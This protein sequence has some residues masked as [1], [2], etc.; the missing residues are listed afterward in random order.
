MKYAAIFL[1][2]ALLLTGCSQ[3]PG[4]STAPSQNTSV[5][6]EPSQST[7]TQ[8]ILP[9][10]DALFSD[11]DFDTSV[12]GGT[13]IIL[14][15]STIRCTGSGVTVSGN[16]ATITEEGT[17][18]L[19]GQLQNGSIRIDTDKQSKVQL[20]LR[21]AAIHCST[22]APICVLQADKVFLT[23]EGSNE[24]SNG[25]SFESSEE[26]VDAVLFSQDDLTINGS[27]SM[28]IRSPGGHGIVAKDELTITGGDFSITAAKHGI[29]A[30]DSL[31]I[32]SG[33]FLIQSGKDAL[34]SDS[35]EE[36]M[37]F[38]YIR[39][40]EFE[41]DATGDGI[42]A[43]NT[44]QIDGGV[45]H[46]TTGGGSENGE[47]HT[48]DLFGPG[49]MG[50]G[51]PGMGRP[52]DMPSSSTTTSTDSSTS[53]K[54]LKAGSN[55][56]LLGGS[57]TINSSD[58][59]LHGN[60][61]V[62]IANGTLTIATGD[63]AIHADAT[64]TISG[65]IVHITESYEGMEAQSIR[66]LGGETTLKASDDGLNAAGGNDQSG[67][68]GRP[69]DHFAAASDSAIEITG[70]SLFVDADG[71]GIDSNGS[72]T[73]TGGYTVVEGPTNGGNGPLDYGGSATI[74]GGTL[75]VTGSVQMAQAIHPNGQGALNLSVGNQNA[76]TVVTIADGDGNT[77]L[78]FTPGKAFAC[79]IVSTPQLVSGQTYHVTVGSVAGDVTAD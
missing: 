32:A 1:T 9:D 39:S 63:D 34:R 72:L 41:L 70:G 44:L 12:S 18:I 30:S 37:G 77:V 75:I 31:C 23:L 54:A 5:S 14:D 69:G 40:G 36:G 51:R 17:Y 35:N 76:H 33:S 66:I 65:G 43:S 55:M 38:V 24:L 19:T 64:L 79:V 58:D 78:T 6:T 10:T 42:S 29:D 15:G 60:S 4:T 56:L 46:L 59:A 61:D 48:E 71:D 50:G 53:S 11:R 22:S 73:V 21:D 20:V 62:T 49:G 7:A 16:T 2:I 3:T 45:Y 67:F 28:T 25:G 27:G 57:F 52:G 8:P 13:E 47:V 26:G 68:G 74:S